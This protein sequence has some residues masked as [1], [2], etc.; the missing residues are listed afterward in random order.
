MKKEYREAISIRM[1]KMWADPEYKKKMVEIH[2]GLQAKE[3]HPLW[4]KHHSEEAKMKISNA[5]IGK[6]VHWNKTKEE[7]F[8]KEKLE[9]MSRI[10]K[11]LHKDPDFHQRA[12]KT[13][14]KNGD[15]P[16]NKGVKMPET[17]IE[18][19]EKLSI[20]QKKYFVENPDARERLSGENSVFWKGGISK[21]PYPFEFDRRLKD[22]IKKRDGHKCQGPSCNGRKSRLCVHHINYDKQNC[23]PVNLIT[24]CNYCNAKANF[25]RDEWEHVFR[26]SI[27]EM[28]P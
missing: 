14:F 6:R 1:K 28:Q 22:K 8:T 26:S 13:F 4:G 17:P 11:E 18:I 24:L 16:W 10:T 19:R 21:L 12:S 25:D 27:R 5:K 9:S 7:V 23:D 2:R 20:A 15:A 3:K